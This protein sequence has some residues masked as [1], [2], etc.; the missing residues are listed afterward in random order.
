MALNQTIMIPA[1]FQACKTRPGCAILAQSAAW[2]N[3]GEWRM[4][5]AGQGMIVSG[6]LQANSLP[7]A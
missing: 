5:N 1:V 4:L 7:F 3:G 6:L 2:Q